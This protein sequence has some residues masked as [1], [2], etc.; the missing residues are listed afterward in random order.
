MIPKC[1]ECDSELVKN[2]Y[3]DYRYTCGSCDIKYIICAQCEDLECIWVDDDDGKGI[4]C[5]DC[6]YFFCPSC[7]QTVG[8]IDEDDNYHCVSCS[9]YD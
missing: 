8:E 6:G 9:H 2:S 4:T 1:N 5:E 3:D 7:W